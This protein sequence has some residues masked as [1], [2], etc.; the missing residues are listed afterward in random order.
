MKK[1]IIV[2]AVLLT[3]C[4]KEYSG[5]VL[6]KYHYGTERKVQLYDTIE[7]ETVVV[8]VDRKTFNKVKEGDC[9]EL[10]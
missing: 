7:Q 1:L 3:G 2:F 4:A 9:I 5:I 6:E 8:R 10:K